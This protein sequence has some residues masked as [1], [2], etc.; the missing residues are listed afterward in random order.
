MASHPRPNLKKSKEPELP[1]EVPNPDQ[2]TI[3]TNQQW[4][5]FLETY[6]PNSHTLSEYRQYCYKKIERL[7][8]RPLL[9]YAAKLMEYPGVPNAIDLND[10]DGFTDL[11]QPV[12]ENKGIDILLHSPGG[13]PGATE[14][15]VKLLRKHFGEVHFL[16]PHSAYSAATMLALSGNS[17]TLHPSAVLGPIDPQINGIPARAIVNGF[18]K[19]KETLV[20]EGPNILPVY[21]P[22][23]DKCS[24]E[25]LEICEDA[26]KLSQKLVSDWL[27]NYMLKGDPNCDEKTKKAVKYFSNYDE[28]LTHSRPLTPDKLDELGLKIQTS[29]AD[30]QGLMWQ[31][32]IQINGFFNISPL[33][34]LYEHTKGPSAWFGITKY[35]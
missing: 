17:I 1:Q 5:G 4:V 16:I 24:L 6:N 23:I 33:I 27:R 26:D 12:K 19:I 21:L 2:I 28:H 31:A 8:G 18:K 30:L 25:L 3:E 32:Y 22:L 7:R 35:E 20:K 29:D 15:I 34:K 13:E 11:I 10:V 14:R 9:V